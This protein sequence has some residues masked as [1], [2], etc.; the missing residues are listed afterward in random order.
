M[1]RF[2][3]IVGTDLFLGYIVTY[4]DKEALSCEGM[5]AALGNIKDTDKILE[6]CMSKIKCKYLFLQFNCKMV[7]DTNVLYTMDEEEVTVKEVLDKGY[8][9][10]IL[11][12]L[13]T[14]KL[15]WKN[16]IE[17]KLE[18]LNPMSFDQMKDYYT[19]LVGAYLKYLPIKEN[20]IQGVNPLEA[21]FANY[22]ERFYKGIKENGYYRL[23]VT[24]FIVKEKRKLVLMIMNTKGFKEELLVLSYLQNR[25]NKPVSLIKTKLTC[26]IKADRNTLKDFFCK[27]SM[28][29][30]DNDLRG[31][32]C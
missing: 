16:G 1:L 8:V 4:K 14:K 6:Y 30:A 25:H 9:E 23:G 31:L 24:G 27:C 22:E 11:T 18:K 5:Y 20:M 13:K 7:S 10:D 19:V 29:V 2:G 28:L 21:F 17:V 15:V 32:K 26:K 3:E 12:K